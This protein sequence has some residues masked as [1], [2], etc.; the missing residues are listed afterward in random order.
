V[1][2]DGRGVDLTAVREH[3][4]RREIAVPE[5]DRDVL[6]L[7]FLPGFS[8][9]RLVTE[10]SGRGIGL[11]VV[12]HRVESIHG[13]VELSS[14]AG[15]GTCVSL[16]V[17][18]TVSTVRALLLT[19]SGQTFV[20][21]LTNLER[22]TRV[23][24]RDLGSATGRDVLLTD[25]APVLVASLAGVL[26]IGEDAAHQTAGKRPIA[27]VRSGARQV[28]FIVD[29]L[30][31]EHEL[32]VKSLGPRLSRVRHF[33]GATVLPTGRVALILNAADL[34]DTAFG[35]PSRPALAAV[36]EQAPQDGRR[37]LLLVEDS[38]TT[39]SL[40]KSI[41]EAS[42]YQVTAAVDGN[43]AWRLL[44]QH[45]A[46]L[47]VA[48]VEMPHMDGFALC[49]AIR[50][51]KRFRELP[52]VLVTAR[53]TDADKARGLD[54]GANAYLPKSTFDQRQLLDVIA[55]LL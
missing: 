3:A 42:G 51:S 22:L 25:G 12:K 24:L 15:K 29:A 34:V 41:L 13:H 26:G 17:P 9:A 44:Q 39:R 52:V 8:T 11:D 10:L 27:I 32:V 18:V 4:R 30:E 35:L 28:A 16:T 50:G 49:E 38:V 45:G 53:E 47:V 40:E 31:A 54:V 46:D 33:A 23:A 37:H 1:A 5:D 7:L 6:R 48:D 36:R 55:Q 14:T 20:L 19:A 43:E 21:P 2:D